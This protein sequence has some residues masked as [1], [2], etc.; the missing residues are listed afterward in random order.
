MLK[1]LQIET[2]D[3][4]NSI[5]VIYTDNTLKLISFYRYQLKYINEKQKKKI[6]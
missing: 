4:I 6:N 5:R 1:V 2:C 3:W